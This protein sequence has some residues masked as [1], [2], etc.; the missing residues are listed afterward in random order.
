MALLRQRLLIDNRV[1]GALLR[2]TG[3]Y[4]VCCATYFGV[5]MLFSESITDPHESAADALFRCLDEFIFWLPG[6]VILAPVIAYDL[7]RITNRFTGPIFRLRKEMIKLADGEDA[8]HLSFRD[9][10]H[11]NDMAELFNR[12]HDE[13][14]ELRAAAQAQAEDSDPAD[15]PDPQVDAAA[16]LF[17]DAE[18][19][20]LVGS[21]QA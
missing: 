17:D 21:N 7:L 3:L 18:S 10:D 5:I 4:A 14:V 11:W 9:E 6:F 20:D 2:R 13:L 19:D 15:T 16:R 1:Q 12:I 8:S